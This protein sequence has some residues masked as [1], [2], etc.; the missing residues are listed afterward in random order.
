[1]RLF[2]LI[3]GLESLDKT[4]TKDNWYVLIQA[5]IKGLANNAK[6]MYKIK[7]FKIFFFYKIEILL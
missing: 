3:G 4:R 6:N 2:F 5:T 1:M 7:I